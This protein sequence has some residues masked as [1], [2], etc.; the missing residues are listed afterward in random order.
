MRVRLALCAILVSCSVAVAEPAGSESVQDALCRLIDNAAQVHGIP[1]D[2]LTSLLWRESS[3]RAG[4]VSR[5][6]AQGI[7]QFMP[8]TA[9]ARGLLD[10]FD[11]EEAIPQAAHLIADL[12]AEFGNLG[13]AAAA[14]NAGAGRV[15]RWLARE[16]L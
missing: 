12:A 16:V 11:P 10:P 7:A 3:F 8:S 2:F 1:A 13:L 5:K 9:I 15:R 4:V 6:G 14:Y